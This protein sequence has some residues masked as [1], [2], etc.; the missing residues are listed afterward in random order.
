MEIEREK[1]DL[2]ATEIVNGGGARVTSYLSGADGVDGDSESLQSLERD[3][4]LREKA[5]NISNQLEMI[6]E[7]SKRKKMTS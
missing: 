5:T 4:H 2:V 6:E 7:S 1:P 3:H